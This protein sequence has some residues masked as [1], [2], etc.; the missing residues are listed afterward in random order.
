[1]A[2]TETAAPAALRIARTYTA[3]REKVF[4]AWTDPQAL[5]RWLAP[6][7]GFSTEVLEL[8]LRPGGRYRIDMIEA[9][10]THRV[11]GTY[12]EVRPPERLVFTWKW[13]G[14]S[15]HLEETRVTIELF[16]RGQETELVLT[17]DRF[18]DPASR[19]EHGKGWNGCLDSLG[20][21]LE[22]VRS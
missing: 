20:R 6:R 17:H 8:D 16:E 3:P 14:E 1:M 13:E 19:D 2:T 15:A 18:T 10:R 22:A 11:A 4:R 7:D 9:G 21:F 5:T 12:L